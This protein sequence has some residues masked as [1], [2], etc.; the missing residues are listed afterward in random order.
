MSDTILSGLLPASRLSRPSVWR[1][2]TRYGFRQLIADRCVDILQPDI[3]WL[4]GLTEAR[5][6]T[7]MAAAYDILVI[8]HGSSVYSYHMQCVVL[9]LSWQH[10][11][12]LRLIM[13]MAAPP[14]TR[15]TT[16]QSQS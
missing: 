5:R 9:A 15:S 12:F 3:T 14:D 6:I 16:A 4:G 8:P 13:R 1:R 10:V 2:Y 11:I 7:A